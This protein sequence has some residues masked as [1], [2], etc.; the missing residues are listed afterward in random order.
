[1]NIIYKAI[2]ITSLLIGILGAFIPLLPSTCFVLLSAWCFSKSSPRWH[3]AL[4][5]NRF[6]GNTLTQW[7]ENREI[8]INARRIAI[9]SMLLSG[10]YSFVV[11]ESFAVKVIIL[12][13]LS[14]SIWAINQIPSSKKPLV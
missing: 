13:L 5:K 9:V 4:R 2:G 12:L 11:F 1:M 6:I 10:T 8:S 3:Q 7:E 14:V